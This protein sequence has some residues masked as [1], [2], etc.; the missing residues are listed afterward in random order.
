MAQI[1][2]YP[3]RKEVADRIFEIL[4]KTLVK[5]KDKKEAYSLAEDLFSPTEKVMLAKRLAIAFLLIKGYRYRSINHILRVSLGTVSSVSLS[6]SRGQDGYKTILKKIADEE[7]L[8]ELFR[9]ILENA[10][11][12][13]AASTKG[14]GAWRYLAQELKKKNSK[15]RK[16][17]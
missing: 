10:V 11:S 8:D 15:R 16:S 13:P 4:I 14:G 17:F 9:S 5:V 6:M 2:K 12:V 3:I 7:K 1:S